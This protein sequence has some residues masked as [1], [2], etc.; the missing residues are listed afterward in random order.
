MA[1]PTNPSASDAAS[2][3]KMKNPEILGEPSSTPKTDYSANGF[4]ASDTGGGA[5]VGYRN[6]R[7]RQPQ[8]GGSGAGSS[9]FAAQDPRR[10]DL[11]NGPIR[12]LGNVPPGAQPV[13]PPPVT[14]VT[15][16]AM[17]GNSNSS[18][19]SSSSDLRVKIIVPQDYITPLTSGGQNELQDFKGVIFPYTPQ[20]T[21]EHKAEYNTVQPLHSNYPINF[22]KNSSVADITIT[23]KFTVQNDKDAMVY[24]A[25]VHLLSAL[26]KMRWGG[27]SG[28][29]DSGSPPPICRLQ[30]YGDFVLKNIPVA[31]V[32]FKH[33]LPDDVDFYTLDKRGNAGSPFNTASVPIRSTITVVCKPM[34]SRREMLS[35]SVTK[36]LNDPAQRSL[37]YL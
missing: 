2:A 27:A 5:F 4:V 1:D 18:S 14:E 28:D 31:I 13:T 6:P 10:T 12:D 35:A 34:Y 16:T 9:E 21:L 17:D 22:Y 36:Y 3:D 11:S 25:T 24:L 37:G 8:H 19:S 7:R 23:G 33:D 20:I 15:T 26:T 32:S 29:F 30:G